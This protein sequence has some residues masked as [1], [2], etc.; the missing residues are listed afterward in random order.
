MVKG[1]KDFHV[2]INQGDAVGVEAMLL[3]NPTLAKNSSRYARLTT[4]ENRRVY[5]AGDDLVDTLGPALSPL[6]R[7]VLCLFEHEDV[8]ARRRILEL[9]YDHGATFAGCTAGAYTVESRGC[10][11]WGE[12]SAYDRKDREPAVTVWEFLREYA[13][14]AAT[15][16]WLEA[17]FRLDVKKKTE[18]GPLTR[19]KPDPAAARAAAAAVA[20]AEAKEAQKVAKEERKKAKEAKARKREAAPSGPKRPQNAYMHY[21]HAARPLL[22]Q[23]NP[24]ASVAQIGKLAGAE[25]RSMCAAARAPY[26]KL[27]AEDTA[28]YERETGRPVGK[29][30]RRADSSDEE[31]DDEESD[32]S[33]EEYEDESDGEDEGEEEEEKDDDDDE[34]DDERDNE[35]E[36]K[37]APASAP[38]SRQTAPRGR[39]GKAAAAP[40]PLAPAVSKRKAAAPAPVAASSSTRAASSSV[41]SGPSSSSAASRDRKRKLSILKEDLAEG[42]IDDVTYRAIVEKLYG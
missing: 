21:V 6:Y 8:D 42:L 24:K 20:A 9:L 39:G 28:R 11:Q 18:K 23:K 14:N 17:T 31:D 15:V 19:P 32:E 4:E 36:G 40:A 27:A 3:Q 26:E 2:K 5:N 34:D 33:G 7:A 22:Q 37:E 13:S 41:A 35:E 16:R 30:R 38:A 1:A 29:K 12:R 10:A 25:W